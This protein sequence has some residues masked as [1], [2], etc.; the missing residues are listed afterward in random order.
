MIERGADGNYYFATTTA[1]FVP[2][3]SLEALYT[4]SLNSV[5]DAQSQPPGFQ[6]GGPGQFNINAASM[7]L[8]SS[9]GIISWGIGSAF[10]PVNY[11][12]LAPWTPSGAAVNVNVS[13]RHQL[14]DLHHCL[15]LWR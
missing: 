9:G 15:H 3:S 1:S 2:P 6:I 8:G 11:A 4:Q 12:S 10:N 5:R 14:A 13:R 7:D